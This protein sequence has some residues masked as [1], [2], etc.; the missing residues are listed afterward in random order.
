MKYVYTLNL[1]APLFFVGFISASAMT[2]QELFEKYRITVKEIRR[3]FPPLL[4]SI[5][6]GAKTEADE[7]KPLEIVIECN[8]QRI[9]LS[10]E[11]NRLVIMLLSGNGSSSS[12]TESTNPLI[13]ITKFSDLEQF[14]HRNTTN[15]PASIDG[16]GHIDLKDL[17]CDDQQFLTAKCLK[18]NEEVVVSVLTDHKNGKQYLCEYNL[19]SRQPTW[20]SLTP[21]VTTPEKS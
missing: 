7:L 6:A 17:C 20:Y 8:D 5:P 13:P 11:S 3:G 12:T 2:R 1:F 9:S 21:K 4:E 15:S 14:D 16:G 19:Q 10:N 18:A